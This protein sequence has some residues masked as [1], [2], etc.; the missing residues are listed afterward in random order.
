[1]N[2]LELIKQAREK[3]G[4]KPELF[5]N[6]EYMLIHTS[7]SSLQFAEDQ[8]FEKV[9]YKGE[10]TNLSTS[11]TELLWEKCTQFDI[12]FSEKSEKLLTLKPEDYPTKWVAVEV[13]S[14]LGSLL[15]HEYEKIITAIEGQLP[16][17]LKKRLKLPPTK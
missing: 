14:M 10:T 7:D 13:K 2:V 6:Q 11:K 16:P 3:A 12:L 4:E 17:E 15:L 1:M 5:I 8:D 9:V